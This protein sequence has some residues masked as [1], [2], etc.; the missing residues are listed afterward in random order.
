MSLAQKEI[1]KLLQ[2]YIMQILSVAD[3]SPRDLRP[4]TLGFHHV[5][6]ILADIG[7]ISEAIWGIRK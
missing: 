1:Y 2:I 5:A 6:R 7:C 4:G 3:L